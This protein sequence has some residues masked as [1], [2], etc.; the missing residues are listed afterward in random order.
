MYFECP[1]LPRNGIKRI[2][3]PS[4]CGNP[5]SA[6]AVFNKV[7]TRRSTKG[8]GI[9]LI[10]FIPMMFFCEWVIRNQPHDSC[11]PY[12]IFAVLAYLHDEIILQDIFSIFNQFYLAEFF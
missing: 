4:P 9:V 1:E 8:G 5:I 7:G 10:M 12:N 11:K 6:L 2:K 3:T